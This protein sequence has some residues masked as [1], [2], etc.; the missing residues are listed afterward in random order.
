MTS[1][2]DLLALVAALGGLTGLAAFVQGLVN[3]RVMARKTEIE[4]LRETIR[5]LRQEIDRLRAENAEL[6]AQIDNLENEND[7]LRRKLGMTE[8]RRPIRPKGLARAD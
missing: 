8:F 4:V 3:A 2:F 5:E 7:Q 1:N 6:R